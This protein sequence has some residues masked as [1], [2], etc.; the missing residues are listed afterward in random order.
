MSQLP[1]TLALLGLGL[2]LSGCGPSAAPAPTPAA[3]TAPIR[4]FAAASLTAPFEAIGRAYEQQFPGSKVELHFAGTPQLVLQIR[5][6]AEVDVFA[7]AD[8]ANMQK[9]VEL[10]KTT[11]PPA[12]FAKNVLAIVVKAG[13]PH[14]IRG[15]PDLAR[16]NLKVA[17]C[18]P[19]VPAGKYARQALQKA[20]ITVQSVS[21]EPSVKA[22][23]SKVQLGEL[24]AGIVY[25]TDT[26]TKGVTAVTIDATW[27]VVA[28]YPLVVLGSGRNRAGGEQFA[29][30]LRSDTSRA[31][32]AEYGFQL[33]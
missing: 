14:G 29:A 11:A 24:D 10:G 5:E 9:V 7:S 17:L 25:T 1:K 6:G 28:S 12:E 15:L 26:R 8:P 32:L 18:G 27:N 16:T 30:F 33:P 21:D 20:S 2:A 13:N 4:V 22:L 3:A 31:V 19:E 23:V